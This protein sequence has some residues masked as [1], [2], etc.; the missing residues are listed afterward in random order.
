MDIHT[1]HIEHVV[2]L[3]LHTILT[4][5]NSWLYRGM[6]GVRWFSFYSLL[7]LLGATAVALRGMIPDFISIVFGNLFV[8]AGYAV[9]FI[10]L[11]EFFGKKSNEFYWQAALFVAAVVTMVLYGSIEPSTSKRL[12]AYSCVLLLQQIHIASFLYRNHDPAI[13]VPT[14]SMALMIGALALSNLTRLVGVSIQGAPHN[15][16]NA[17]PFLAWILIVNSG[18]QWGAMVAFVWMTAAMLRGKLETQALTDPLTNTLNRRGIELAAEQYILACRRD[19]RPL[20]AMI[21]DLDKFKNINDTYG[22]HCGD[23]TLVT[24]ASCLQQGLRSGDVLARIG[25][26]EFAILLPN[27]RG[28][29]AAGI[30]ARL[31]ENISATEIAYDH[32]RLT[33]TASFGLA[34]LQGPVSSWEQLFVKCDKALY[35]EKQADASRPTPKNIRPELGLLPH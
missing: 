23:A 25:G 30:A 10:S 4:V 32:I 19:S 27:T 20:S 11:R 3:A 12:I 24:V 22:H 13:R 28:E 6:K 14:A 34:Q 15:Y 18:L 31:R 26:D 35:E 1:L 33:V 2:F 29:E 5:A 21:V 17:G 16:L 7:V 8:V 9:L